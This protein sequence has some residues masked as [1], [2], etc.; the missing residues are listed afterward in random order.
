MT[1]APIKGSLK[2]QEYFG[3]DFDAQR[4]LTRPGYYTAVQMIT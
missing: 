3:L 1:W 2:F 4:T